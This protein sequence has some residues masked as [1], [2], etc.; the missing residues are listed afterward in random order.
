M[1]DSQVRRGNQSGMSR[2]APAWSARCC[3]GGDHGVLDPRPVRSATVSSRSSPRRVTGHDCS[4][5]R[6]LSQTTAAC[7]TKPAPLAM[8]DGRGL[9]G[10]KPSRLNPSRQAYQ[11][12]VPLVRHGSTVCLVR[13]QASLNETSRDVRRAAAP[14]RSM[15]ST[16]RR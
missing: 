6:H 11:R 4:R 9:D 3:Q 5:S 1:P 14:S 12:T 15:G 7:L 10:A 16:S 2:P 13:H 8:H